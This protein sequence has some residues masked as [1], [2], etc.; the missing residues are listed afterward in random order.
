MS[1]MAVIGGTGPQGK[2]LAYR[3]ARGGHEIVLG[4][5]DQERAVTA[6]AELSER[7][8]SATIRGTRN[9]QAAEGANLV[10]L[11][12]PYNGHDALVAALAA[13]TESVT[14]LRSP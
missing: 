4:S 6:A 7:V 13:R 5:R 14:P 1:I 9:D 3:F 11:A 2:G 8:Q 10:L 12:V